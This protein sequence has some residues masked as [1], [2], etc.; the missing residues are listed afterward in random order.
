MHNGAAV[1]HYRFFLPELAENQS[2]FLP[3]D[4][5]HHAL[6]VLRLGAGT[7]IE[8]FNGRGAGAQAVIERTDKKGVLVRVT[9]DIS[10][11]PQPAPALTLATA[12]PKGD[13]AQWLIEQ[14]SQLNVTALRWLECDRNV[15][16]YREESGKFGR[17]ER[18]ALE[19]AKQCGRNWLMSIEPPQTLE[20]VVASAGDAIILWCDPRSG[21]FHAIAAPQKSY[22]A[23]IGPEGGWSQRECELL[24]SYTRDGKVMPIR[25]GINIMRIETACAAIAAITGSYSY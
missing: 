15:V 7:E 2:F 10:R 13:R 8:L 5:A 12:M 16:K 22:I 23:L 6:H 1:D 18:Y 20:Q 9:S 11:Q 14:C 24:N 3:Q 4:E 17:L 25:L 21:N 19:A